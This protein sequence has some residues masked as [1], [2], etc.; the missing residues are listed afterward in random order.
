MNF[1]ILHRSEGCDNQK[2][3]SLTDDHWTQPQHK[4]WIVQS[5]QIL[6][7]SYIDVLASKGTALSLKVIPKTIKIIIIR[8]SMFAFL[9]PCHEKT[10]QLKEP[11][12]IKMQSQKN[13]IIKSH[14]PISFW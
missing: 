7:Q 8:Q 14:H 5:E 2:S 3:V 11:L 4:L 10:M 12:N 13:P 1:A 9:A 6:K